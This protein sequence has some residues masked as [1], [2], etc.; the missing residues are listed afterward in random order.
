MSDQ[1][2]QMG[3][4]ICWAVFKEDLPG[5]D[6]P[7]EEVA[8]RAFRMARDDSYTWFTTS[9]DVQFRIGCG[10]LLMHYKDSEVRVQIE[11]TL[12]ALKA[13]SAM[14]SGVPVDLGAV[15]NEETE[16]LPLLPWYKETAAP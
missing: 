2:V 4:S 12:R 7:V 8:K 15:L 13:L 11:N 3:T 10:V 14:M 9:D 1:E 16:T 5:E 6:T